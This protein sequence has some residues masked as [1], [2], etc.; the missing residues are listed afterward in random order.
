M[1]TKPRRSGGYLNYGAIP[2]KEYK[3]GAIN[4]AAEPLLPQKDGS[5]PKHGPVKVRTMQQFRQDRTGKR[6]PSGTSLGWRT[7]RP[8]QRNAGSDNRR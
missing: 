8:S 4:S 7:N 6:K 3:Y 1:K 2:T 5:D